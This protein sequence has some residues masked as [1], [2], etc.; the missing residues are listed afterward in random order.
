MSLTQKYS[1]K[2]TMLCFFTI[3]LIWKIMVL[4]TDFEDGLST[5]K[6]K[7]KGDECLSHDK[8]GPKLHANP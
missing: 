6:C 2:K 3:E 1:C 5:Y 8:P 7:Y 4:F